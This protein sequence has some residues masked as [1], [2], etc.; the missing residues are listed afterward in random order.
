MKKCF[1]V[2]L[3][4]A[5]LVGGSAIGTDASSA[6]ASLQDVPEAELIA[7]VFQ[8]SQNVAHFT[9]NV[10]AL[11]VKNREVGYAWHW[12]RQA[13]RPQVL[14]AADKNQFRFMSDF[15]PHHD[16]AMSIAWRWNSL[17]ITV[18]DTRLLFVVVDMQERVDWEIESTFNEVIDWQRNS[19]QRE[20]EI[21][22]ESLSVQQGASFG[23]VITNRRNPRSWFM[24]PVMWAV[25]DNKIC[26]IFDKQMRPSQSKIPH[27]DATQWVGGIPLSDPR[28][29]LRFGVSNREELSR[30]YF[31]PILKI[32]EEE[33]KKMATGGT[34]GLVKRPSAEQKEDYERFIKSNLENKEQERTT[35]K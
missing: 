30:E 28:Q 35:K 3:I 32:E 31:Q 12:L 16:D 11:E 24:N 22:V 7:A 13:V 10:I 1:F 20:A 23:K 8:Q 5:S 17:N 6:E 14:R 4:C 27:R 25:K 19:I 21:R 29:W 2:C 15:G 34:K 33:S 9:T 26:F 18:V